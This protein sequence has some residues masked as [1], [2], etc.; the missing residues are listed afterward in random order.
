MNRGKMEQETAEESFKK[1]IESIEQQIESWENEYK[2]ISENPESEY[3]ER[4]KSI[5]SNLIEGL[6]NNLAK[7]QKPN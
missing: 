5:I 1:M 4:M 7:V 2:K 3:R 6:K